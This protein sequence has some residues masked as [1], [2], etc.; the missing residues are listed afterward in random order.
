MLRAL[1]A[2]L[3][4]GNVVDVKL[5]DNITL[6]TGYI[7]WET[8]SKYQRLKYQLQKKK[9]NLATSPIIDETDIYKM[10]AV[11]CRWAS[12]MYL[13][14]QKDGGE[15]MTR[16][17]DITHK[18]RQENCDFNA[19]LFLK[20]ETPV[21]FAVWQES[22]VSGK[23]QARNLEF[24]WGKELPHNKKF[25]FVETCRHLYQYGIL[26]CTLAE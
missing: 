4:A 18:L 16:L 22:F 23:K 25:Q 7:G 13:E 11:I 2:D 8:G 17:F 12:R 14:K 9:Y 1:N 10:R 21:G 15:T 3:K 5:S 24:L 19:L 26:S 6:D 20:D